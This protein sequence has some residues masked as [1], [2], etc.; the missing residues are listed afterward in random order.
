ML[1]R[2]LSSA[3]GCARLSNDMLGVSGCLCASAA[4]RLVC[5]LLPVLHPARVRLKQSHADPV[6]A[7]ALREEVGIFKAT[8][9]PGHCLDEAPTALNPKR[10]LVLVTCQFIERT[11]T[12]LHPPHA[13]ALQVP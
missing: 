4:C 9:I 3:Q 6:Q 12:P 10:Q 5:I 13:Y 2:Q 1:C 8:S 7:L 11:Y